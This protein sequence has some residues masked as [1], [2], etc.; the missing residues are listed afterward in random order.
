MLQGLRDTEGTKPDTSVTGL[1]VA[2][3][4]SKSMFN[5]LVLV[6]QINKLATPVGS[7]MVASGPVDGYR[8][9]NG[10]ALSLSSRSPILAIY[11]FTDTC[12]CPWPISNVGLK[13]SVRHD[14]SIFLTEGTCTCRILH[15]YGGTCNISRSSSTSTCYR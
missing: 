5:S 7:L 1:Y 2:N 3:P 10:Q 6:L 13:I 8:L 15:L 14:V 4:E 9:Y 12:F 11:T